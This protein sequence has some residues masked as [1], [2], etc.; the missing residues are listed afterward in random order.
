[1]KFATK[2]IQHYP[3]HHKHI[4][5][6]LSVIRQVSHTRNLDCSA[7]DLYIQDSRMSFLFK[8]CCSSTNFDILGV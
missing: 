4:A 6:S 1:M 2:L 3:P 8:L 5:T 7:C